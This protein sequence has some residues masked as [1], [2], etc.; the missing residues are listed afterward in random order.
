[1]LLSVVVA[2]V[3]SPVLCATL[4]KPVPKGHEAARAARLVSAARS[5]VGL[6]DVFARSRDWYVRA[7]GP[8]AARTRLRY[9]VA[10]VL[11]VAGVGWVFSRMPKSYLPDEDQGIL[12][13]QV[14]MPTGATIEQTQEV[15]NEIQDYFLKN[16]KE[17]IESVSP[18][19][20]YS[21]AGRTQNNGMV[22]IKLKD[23]KLRDRKDLRV[24][25][26]AARA[27]K[28][29]FQNPQPAWCSFSRHRRS[30]SW[31]KPMV[32]ISSCRTAAAWVTQP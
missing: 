7:G 28:A 32:S 16:E 5:S 23:W 15:L 31:V 18:I 30:S 14:M 19:A 24:N 10:F 29:A 22:F 21:F 17:A 2:L 1:M 11:I 4:L 6:S 12:F 27:T 9:V 8:R 3:L 25:A 26:I 13:A 20:G